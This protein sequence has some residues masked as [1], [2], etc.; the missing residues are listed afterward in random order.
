MKRLTKTSRVGLLATLAMALPTHAA[1]IAV[2]YSFSGI[3]TVVDA[4]ATTL[5]LDAQASGSILSGDAGLDA[6]W[7][8]ISY[9]DQAVLDLTTGLLHGNFIATLQDGDTITGTVDEDDSA[10]DATTGTGPFTQTLTFTGGT[11]GFAGVSGSVSGNGFVG[12]TNFMVSGSGN[13][14]TSAVPEPASGAFLLGGL[15]FL[16]ARR[17]LRINSLMRKR[18][19]CV[20]GLLVAC[21]FT[22]AAKADTLVYAIGSAQFGTMDLNTGAF[23][24]VADTPPILQYLANAPNKTLLTM[25]FDGNLDSINPTTG[26]VSVIGPTGFGDCS[27]AVV[28]NLSN[29]QLSFGQALGKYYATDFGNNLYSINPLTGQATLIGKTGIPAVTFLPAIPGADG[30]FD[31]YDENLFEA[32]GKL[33]ANFDTGHFQ[34]PADPASN[35][36][37]TPTTAAVLYEIDPNTGAA[38]KVADTAFGQGTIA[39]ING[40]VYSFIGPDS[41]IDTLD[42]STGNSAFVSNSDANLGLVGGV[43]AVPE[44]APL[45]LLAAGLAAVLFSARRQKA[46]KAPT[47][48]QQGLRR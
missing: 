44:P 2:T 37:V 21:G 22:V 19:V 45:A 26:G 5:T 14:D 42:V 13:L 38:T 35:P 27:G 9:S 32:G 34:P 43:A 48:A 15:A 31:F 46:T 24:K 6:V 23:T 16:I 17:R 18:N 3:G 41:S 20:A 39:N 1:S 36:V 30:S 12:T 4:T 8:P 40:T 25:S 47:Q 33:Y 10:V 11:G 28:A 7:N 29:C